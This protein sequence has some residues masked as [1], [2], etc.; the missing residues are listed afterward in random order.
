VLVCVDAQ[1]MRS[2]ECFCLNGETLDR[3]D[4]GFSLLAT[5]VG[6]GLPPSKNPKIWATLRDERH[7]QA[8]PA[9][10]HFHLPISPCRNGGTDSVLQTDAAQHEN[11]QPAEY[12]DIW[13]QIRLYVRVQAEKRLLHVRCPVRSWADLLSHPCSL[14]QMPLPRPLHYD[15]ACCTEPQMN[16]CREAPLGLR[17]CTDGL[18]NASNPRH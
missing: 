10:F 7:H 12:Q 13:I 5:S 11:R 15:A 17:S 2:L 14:P 6:S 4:D 9:V 3:A 18:V 8:G 16:R 1:R